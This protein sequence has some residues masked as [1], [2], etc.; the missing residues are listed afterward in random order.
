MTIKEKLAAAK[1]STELF[2]CLSEEEKKINDIMAEISYAI[3]DER[4]K[5]GMSQKEFAKLFGVSQDTID[6]W[7]GCARDFSPQEIHF[8]LS[9]ILA[10]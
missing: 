9:T 7:E 2:D 6:Q 8:I 5:R 4:R 3:M 1:P 10:G